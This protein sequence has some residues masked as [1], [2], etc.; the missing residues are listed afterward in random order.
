MK[1]KVTTLRAAVFF[2]S[3]GLAAHAFPATRA[4]AA[5][6]A[7]VLL[8]VFGALVSVPFLRA[9]GGALRWWAGITFIVTFALEAAG[10]ATGRIFGPYEYGPGLGPHI[11]GVPPVIGFNWV[12][13]VLACR[14]VAGML[15][16]RGQGA[17]VLPALRTLLTGALCVAFDWV[18]EP[19]AVALDYWSWFG[20]PIPVQ[21]YIAWFFIATAAAAALELLAA[22]A[23]A[24]NQVEIA[25]PPL[26]EIIHYVG[27]Q[28]IFFIG[29]RVLIAF[30]RL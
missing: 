5:P 29:I 10:V 16:R 6:F 11:L 23:S 3:I 19:V 20:A 9:A 4:L 24:R 7:P 28:L 21:N 30:G 1:L 13:V 27:I 22:R 2:Y 17:G 26:D 25:L 12:L 14:G 18:M 8:L 15:L